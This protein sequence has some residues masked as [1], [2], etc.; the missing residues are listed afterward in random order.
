M[1]GDYLSTGLGV[2]GLSWQS[3]PALTEVEEVVT[4]VSAATDSAVLPQLVKAGENLGGM[5]T[6]N[7]V[8]CVSCDA[9]RQRTILQ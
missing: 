2:L 5:T 9:E 8:E 3:S 1:L 6:D 4:D 7:L